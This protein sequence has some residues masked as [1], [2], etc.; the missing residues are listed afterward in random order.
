MKKFSRYLW[1]IL[2]LI[3]QAVNVVLGPLLNLLLQPKAAR[4]GDPDETLSSVFGKN[5]QAGKCIGCR[6]VCRV[7]NRIDP[8]HCETSIEGDEGAKAL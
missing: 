1:N 6:L 3:D 4:F 2:V 8:G 5:V 7:L